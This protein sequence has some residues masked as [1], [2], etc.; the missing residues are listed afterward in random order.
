MKLRVVLELLGFVSLTSAFQPIVRPEPPRTKLDL[1]EHAIFWGITALCFSQPDT[2]KD[3]AAARPL[4]RASFAPTPA[5]IKHKVAWHT[6][7]YLDQVNRRK[8]ALNVSSWDHHLSSGVAKL[9]DQEESNGMEEDPVDLVVE[10]EEEEEEELTTITME[11]EEEEEE[12]T[13]DETLEVTTAETTTTIASTTTE[14]HED[15]PTPPLLPGEA[16]D[17][18]LLMQE[19]AEH[20][21]QEAAPFTTH[22]RAIPQSKEWI[23][24]GRKPK[25]VGPSVLQSYQP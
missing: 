9:D 2:K 22:P 25:T 11:K 20:L 7:N 15:T 17:E 10:E 3:F 1:W 4:P 6:D 19:I 24:Y 12:E 21:R 16:L 5:D 13:M 8:V 18:Q 14:Y 23:P